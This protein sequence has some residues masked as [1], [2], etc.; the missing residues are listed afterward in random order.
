MGILV[1][2]S[3]TPEPVSRGQSQSC[4]VGVP[5][6]NEI[7]FYAIVAIDEAG[8][9]GPISNVISVFINEKTSTTT[10][11]TSTNA[12]AL[13]LLGL[14]AGNDDTT[15]RARRMKVVYMSVG[16]VSGLVILIM[17]VVV[18]ILVRF[19]LR[20]KLS[21]SDETDSKA[22]SSYKGFEEP[23]KRATNSN[24]SN[25]NNLSDSGSSLTKKGMLKKMRL[26]SECDDKT[27]SHWL[28]SLPRSDIVLNNTSSGLDVTLESNGGTIPRTHVKN[29]SVTKTNPYRHKVSSLNNE[30][31]IWRLSSFSSF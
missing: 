15:V 29:H 20:P 31:S 11:T 24:T 21:E 5:W 8:N 17:T 2:D 28:D 14:D 19:R 6:P 30:L 3:F 22:S 10:T 26:R 16:I 1:H 13:G 9:R 4:T 12:P 25:N 7:F 23:A 27:L 18:L